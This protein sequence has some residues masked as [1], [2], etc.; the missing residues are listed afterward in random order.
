[1]KNLIS[2]EKVRCYP[3]LLTSLKQWV[4]NS[5]A[6]NTV[7]RRIFQETFV[8]DWLINFK[9]NSRFALQ[10]HEAPDVVTDPHLITYVR[11]VFENDIREFFPSRAIDSRVL[12]AHYKLDIC[13]DGVQSM[14]GR[15]AVLIRKKERKLLILSGH[16]CFTEKHLHSEIWIKSC[17]LYFKLY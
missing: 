4:V 13:T 1:V 3:L 6:G 17:R 9:K 12:N 11:Y 7:G 14:S 15:N 5:L 2:L 8:I 10:L 16:F